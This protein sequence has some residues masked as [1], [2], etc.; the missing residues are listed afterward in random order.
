M[1]PGAPTEK[2]SV[3]ALTE[4]PN[5]STS[6]TALLIKLFSEIIPASSA[7]NVNTAPSLLL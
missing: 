3:P 2:Y 4:M 6:L 1:V 7:L 5:S